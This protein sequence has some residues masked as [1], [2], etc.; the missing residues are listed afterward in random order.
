MAKTKEE[1]RAYKREWSRKK[2]AN[3]SEEDIAKRD[4]YN[5]MWRE[6]NVEYFQKH[7]KEYAPKY[8]DRKNELRRTDEYREKANQKQRERNKTDIQFVMKR[9]LRARIYQALKTGGGNKLGGLWDLLGCS[10]EQL[11]VHLEKQF[12]EGMNWSNYGEWHIDHIKPCC[13]FDLSIDEQ[14]AKCFHYTNLQP[15]WASDNQS[16]NGRTI[17]L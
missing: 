6:N 17:N 16:K 4:A 8:K 10:I 5:K 2:R 7:R 9:R 15:L 14:Q 11:K 13:S 12:S 1:L 3:M